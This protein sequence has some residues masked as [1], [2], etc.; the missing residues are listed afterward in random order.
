MASERP[1]ND[2]RLRDSTRPASTAEPEVEQ[3]APHPTGSSWV[4]W[5]KRIAFAGL[6]LA[7]VAAAA[8]A[9][10][11]VRHYEKDPPSV[12]ESRPQPAPDGARPRARRH[13]LGELFVERPTWSSRST[14]CRTADEGRRPRRR[15]R[16]LLRARRPQLPRMLRAIAVNLRFVPGARQGGSTITQQVIKNVPLTPEKTLGR[17]FPQRSPRGVTE[18]SS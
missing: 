9:Q 14:R 5:L 1:P 10:G 6:V 8:K 3:E 16:E 4:V 17:Q 13:P 18:Q 12:A 2:E 15:G 7:A 11:F